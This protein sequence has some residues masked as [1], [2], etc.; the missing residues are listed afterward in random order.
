MLTPYYERDGITIYRGDCLEVMPQLIEPFDLVVTSPP[1][2][3]GVSSGGGLK[4]ALKS[5]K[6]VSARLAHGY[7]DYDD[8]MPPNEYLAWQR[9]ALKVMWA[10][11]SPTGAIYYNHKPRIQNGEVQLPLRFNPGLPLR[12]IIIWA[13]A[14][15]INFATT[16]YVP[17]H[18][19][20]MV[21]AKHGFRLKSKGASGSGDVWYFPQ[22]P[23]TPHPAPFPIG[24]PIRAI[25]TTNSLHICDPFMGSGTT[26]VAAQQL[27][28]RAVGIELSE[29][30]CEIAVERLRQRSLWQM[31]AMGSNKSLQPIGRPVQRELFPEDETPPRLLKGA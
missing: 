19:W 27:G 25:E 24:I 11:L 18:E 21:L 7:E 20:I 2:N 30:Y 16:H 4:G 26:L 10:A 5:G 22:K 14:G 1:Y 29:E 15:G 6:W 12:Q 3:L 13:R 17:T 28:R 8:A 9:N 31:A 23:N